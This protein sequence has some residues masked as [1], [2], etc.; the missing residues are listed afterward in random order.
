MNQRTV[1][2]FPSPLGR[3]LALSAIFQAALMVQKIS[4][5]EALPEPALKTSLE[6]LFAL[7]PDSLADI[8][9]EPSNLFLGYQLLKAAFKRGSDSS[10]PG[11]DGS[12]NNRNQSQAS[13]NQDSQNKIVSI[14]RHR[15]REQAAESPI[16]AQQH[17]DQKPLS[18]AY[19]RQTVRYALGLLLLEQKLQRES[20]K[21]DVIRSRLKQCYKQRQFTQTDALTFSETVLQPSI[22]HNLAQIYLDTAGTFQFRIQV[23]GQTAALKKE[24]IADK[25]RAILLAGLRAAMLWRQLGGR[26]WQLLFSRKQ[27]IADV[28]KLQAST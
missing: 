28:A 9:P 27:I 19:I 10:V 14:N 25:I 18:T 7:D 2:N 1:N 22:I 24:E 26:R 23:Q 5:G 4:Q 15:D 16:T 11:R 20:D 8:F 12:R 3:T 17:P 21:L 6:S 13:Q